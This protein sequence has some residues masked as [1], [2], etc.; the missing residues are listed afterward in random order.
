LGS[1]SDPGGAIVQ[2][3]GFHFDVLSGVLGSPLA[4]KRPQQLL[5]EKTSKREAKYD[6]K[7]INLATIWA[8]FRRN[9]DKN[10]V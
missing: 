4:Q 1:I 3:L 2:A 5:Y 8:T 6:K 10:V 9:I 7:L